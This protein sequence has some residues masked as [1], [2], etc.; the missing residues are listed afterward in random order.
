MT[1]VSLPLIGCYNKLTFR[2]KMACTDFHIPNYRSL[3]LIFASFGQCLIHQN[4]II[5]YVAWGT[6]YMHD[7]SAVCSTALCRWLS[8]W[9]WR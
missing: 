9:R 2:V 3:L 8:Y 4:K 1:A 7:V 6:F 5:L